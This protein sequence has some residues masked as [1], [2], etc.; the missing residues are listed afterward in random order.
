MQCQSLFSGK[1]KETI[2]NLASDH[3][4]LASAH[5]NMASAQFAQK[6]VEILSWEPVNLNII[7]YV[8]S[9]PVR[10]FFVI[11]LYMCT[12]TCS[13]TPKHLYNNTVAGIQCKNHVS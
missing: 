8:N 9:I 1:N 13:D 2:V 10:A 5:V 12:N 6:M 4:K 7:P 11:R 3:V